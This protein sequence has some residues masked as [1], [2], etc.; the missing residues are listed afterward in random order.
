MKGFVFSFVILL[1]N[2]NVI[3][4]GAHTT[5]EVHEVVEKIFQENGAFGSVGHFTQW[6]KSNKD[7]S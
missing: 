4:I 1:L 3:R 5:D 6:E 2:Q 7:D